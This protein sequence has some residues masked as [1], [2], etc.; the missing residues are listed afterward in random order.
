MT[1]APE[2]TSPDTVD[3][4]ELEDLEEGSC[5]V[6]SSTYFSILTYEMIYLISAF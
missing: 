1:A 4:I 5:E 2:P 3:K 6:V